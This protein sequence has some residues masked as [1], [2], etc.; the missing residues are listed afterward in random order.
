M[1]NREQVVVETMTA[2][3]RFGASVRSMAVV[4]RRILGFVLAAIGPEPK[5]PRVSRMERY[6]NRLRFSRPSIAATYRAVT[7]MSRFATFRT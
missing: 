6:E 4:V 3:Y 7:R 5:I 1:P 2:I